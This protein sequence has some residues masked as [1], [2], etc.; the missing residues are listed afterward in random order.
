MSVSD[1]VILFGGTSEER[2]V[3]VAS[4][5]NLATVLPEADVWFQAPDG[6]VTPC[7]R[8]ALAAHRDA[9]TT[10]FRLPGTPRWPTLAAALDAPEA[11]GKAF[12]LG[13]HGG[14]GEDGTVQRE[15][16]ARGL[17]FTGSGSEASAAGFDKEK[18]KARVAQAGGRVMEALEVRGD[19][20][21]VARA[22]SQM[23]SRHGRLVAK[24]MRGGSSVGL[25]HV[26]GPE[27][28]PRVAK[29]IASRPEVPYVA[30]AFVQGTELT[31][32]VVDGPD[33]SVRALPC[34][35]VRLD[36][37]RAF[38]FEGK[39]LARGTVEIT[40]AEVPAPLFEAAQRLAVTAHQAM[41]CQGYSRTDII[42][43]AQGPVFLEINTLP[44][45]TKASFIPQQLSAEGTSI[46]SFLEG[47]LAL[48]RRRAARRP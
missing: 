3:S 38:D 47:Q 19:E 17:A 33:G 4:A 45:M 40:P 5:Q 32:G 6:S 8:E 7:P 11:K 22:L 21:E 42:L 1:V 34:S 37:G 14:E 31:V 44:G 36:P 46:R 25:H 35:E 28:V 41:G 43:G 27:D 23:L 12:L 26:H 18:A 29:D 30:E 13:F 16:E 9:Y 48:A 2:R 24:P 39:Y 15:L 20:A 10:D